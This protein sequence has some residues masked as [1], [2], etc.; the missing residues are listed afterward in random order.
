MLFLL[1]T[2]MDMT[3]VLI[4]LIVVLL[5]LTLHEVAHGVAAL[6]SGDDTAKHAGRLTLDPRAHLSTQ[7]F[8]AILFLPIGWGIPVPI[9]SRKFKNLR[10]GIFFVSIAGILTNLIICFLAC[11]TWSII[12]RFGNFTIDT[13]YSIRDV[14]RIIAQINIGLAIFNLLPIPP[15]DGSKILWLIAPKK[16]YPLFARV[17]Q[18]GFMLLFAV[19]IFFNAPFWW[20]VDTAFSGVANFASM[21]VNIF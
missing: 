15:L 1:R 7:G 12:V 4:A 21:L 13:M 18:Y 17:E 9:N 6:W 2:G 20:L 14:L 11:L 8:L 19:I 5:S 3:Q 16:M 10:L